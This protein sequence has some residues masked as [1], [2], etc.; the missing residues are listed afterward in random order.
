MSARMK[1]VD[2]L[3]MEKA[4]QAVSCV[5]KLR[6]EERSSYLSALMAISYKL[7]RTVEDDGFVRGWLEAALNE[8]NTESPDVSIREL[9]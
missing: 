1:N 6:P 5:Q 4:L 8:V 2:N 7:L 9:N 3:M